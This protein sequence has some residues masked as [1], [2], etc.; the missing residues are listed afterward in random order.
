MAF[1][2]WIT[3][4]SDEMTS[5][6]RTPQILIVIRQPQY[7]V[8]IINSLQ[9]SCVAVMQ[10]CAQVM[11]TLDNLANV[12]Q[13]HNTKLTFQELF[14]YGIVPVVNENDTVAVEELHF[15]DNDT[16]SAK[17]SWSGLYSLVVLQLAYRAFS[18]LWI[19]SV[20]LNNDE[21]QWGFDNWDTLRAESSVPLT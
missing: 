3:W 10:T 11:L 14:N 4:S 9:C 1:I 20:K 13:Y 8:V 16:L 7:P 6:Y 19:S 2:I 21:I 15:G 18:C 12:H 17:V 5:K